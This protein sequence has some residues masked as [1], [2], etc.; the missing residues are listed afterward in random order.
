VRLHS[1]SLSTP[2]SNIPPPTLP[3]ALPCSRTSTRS[4]GGDLSCQFR[5]G[6]TG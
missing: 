3:A 5:E 1:R 4:G 2:N 6:K